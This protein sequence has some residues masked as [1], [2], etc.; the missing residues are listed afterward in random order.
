VQ[1]AWSKCSAKEWSLS[2]TCLTSKQA[3]TALKEFLKT[4]QTLHKEIQDRLGAVQ[5]LEDNVVPLEDDYDHHSLDDTSVSLQSVISATLAAV[6][7]QEVVGL[8]ATNQEEDVWSYNENGE[9]WTDTGTLPTV[10]DSD[11][12]A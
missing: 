10:E 9:L 1:Q 5:G 6:P 12:I 3:H 4:D 11:E 7:G 8:T 2:E